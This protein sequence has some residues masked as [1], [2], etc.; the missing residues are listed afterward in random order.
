MRKRLVTRY[1]RHPWL[2]TAVFAY[3]LF[4]GVEVVRNLLLANPLD[5]HDE[6][7]SSWREAP[8]DDGDVALLRWAGPHSTIVRPVEGPVLGLSLVHT[9]E[10]TPGLATPVTFVVDGRQ[11]DAYPLTRPG[12]YSFRYYLPSILGAE[13]WSEVEQAWAARARSEAEAARSERPPRWQELKPWRLPPEPPSLRIEMQV[14]TLRATPEEASGGESTV[15]IAD[16]EWLAELPPDGT[17]FHSY[18]TDANGAWFRWTRSWAALPLQPRGREAVIRMRAIHPEIEQLPVT[19]DIFWNAD[20]LQ[21]VSIAWI[22]WAN[23][24]VALPDDATGNGVLS[25][26]VSRTWSPARAGVSPDTRELGVGF[27]GVRW[28]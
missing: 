22:G 10:D 7:L 24:P 11:L 1:R 12:T 25:I 14:P 20:L 15:G 5:K 18:E 19:V 13:R 17:G 27:A 8:T 6:G 4:S 28:R 2:A 23:F 26:H 16:V 3:L 9:G 21:T